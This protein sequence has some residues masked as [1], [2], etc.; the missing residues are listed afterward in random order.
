MEDKNEV[1]ASIQRN[2]FLHPDD[3][4]KRQADPDGMESLRQEQTITR[5]EGMLDL[6]VSTCDI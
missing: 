6:Y 4:A 2:Y 1:I 3:I 5:Y